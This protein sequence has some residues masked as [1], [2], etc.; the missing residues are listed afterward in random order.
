MLAAILRVSMP[1]FRGPRHASA[2]IVVDL[3]STSGMPVTA[4]V[5]I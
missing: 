1:M 2:L 3:D 5:A 4:V